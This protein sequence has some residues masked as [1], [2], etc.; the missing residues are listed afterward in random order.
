V[1]AFSTLPLGDTEAARLLGKGVSSEINKKWINPNYLSWFVCTFV[2][3]IQ[4]L[5][6]F[7]CK[8]VTIINFSDQYKQN[9]EP[10][11]ALSFRF[12]EMTMREF[13]NY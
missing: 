13:F 6:I 5:A 7:K 3:E 11:R 10:F 12:W 1:P 2:F 9:F 8:K 4:R